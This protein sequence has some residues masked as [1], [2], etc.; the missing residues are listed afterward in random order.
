MRQVV[1]KLLKP[2]HAISVENGLTHPGTPDINC[3]LGWIECKAT[4]HW[5][6]NPETIVRLDHDLTPQQRVF[7]V[8]RRRAGGACWVLLTISGEWLLF[9]GAVA[10]EHLGRATRDQLYRFATSTWQKTPTRE[11]LI[12][13][14]ESV[15]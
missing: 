10:A 3:T 9:D 12:R 15:N 13:C 6:V 1:V 5:P 4:E 11:D 8:R 14:L 7:A 2:L